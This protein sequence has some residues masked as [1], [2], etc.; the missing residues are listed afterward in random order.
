M[1]V[2]GKGKY[3]REGENPERKSQYWG[4]FGQSEEVAQ[5][6]RKLVKCKLN[7]RISQ[8]RGNSGKPPHDQDYNPNC[9]HPT[10]TRKL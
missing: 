2:I 4:H 8:G 5:R 6:L 10:I 9:L 1:P 3:P 7:F